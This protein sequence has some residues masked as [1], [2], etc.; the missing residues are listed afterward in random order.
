MGK[1]KLFRG[2]DVP[3][4]LG[5]NY[6][7]F[8]GLIGIIPIVLSVFAVLVSWNTK[9]LR[10][11]ILKA[12]AFEKNA[13]EI[14]KNI[15]NNLDGKA[16]QK[17]VELQFKNVQSMLDNFEKTY[18][19]QIDDVKKSHETLTQGIQDLNSNLTQIMIYV[20]SNNGG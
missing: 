9:D 8:F 11:Q 6:R 14:H 20:K 4:I 10:A 18:Q 5:I 2:D 3:K 19:R 16:E 7:L 17:E 12:E 13:T 1:E 15:K